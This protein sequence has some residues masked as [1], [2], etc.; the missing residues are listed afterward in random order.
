M[1]SAKQRVYVM[2][3]ALKLDSYSKSMYYYDLAS[4]SFHLAPGML[5]A[6]WLQWIASNDEIDPFQM[7]NTFFLPESY[8]IQW[9]WVLQ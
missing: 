4:S 7:H 5:N 3:G 8:N 1:S 6:P 9:F 2:G